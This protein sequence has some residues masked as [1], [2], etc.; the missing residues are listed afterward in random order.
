M[1]R[2]VTIHVGQ[3]GI[4]LHAVHGC[5]WKK[6]LLE[7]NILFSM[8]LL[9]RPMP[10]Y[11]QC[12]CYAA[13]GKNHWGGSHSGDSFVADFAAVESCVR[14]IAHQYRLSGGCHPVVVV[15]PFPIESAIAPS[16]LIRQ[17]TH[18]CPPQIGIYKNKII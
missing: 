16:L 17:P 9:F 2:V 15:S 5:H 6:E 4:S 12:L 8:N 11:C 3:A 14:P 13:A 18:E 1:G 10:C 7:S